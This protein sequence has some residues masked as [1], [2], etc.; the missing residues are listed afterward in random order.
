MQDYRRQFAAALTWHPGASPAELA[1]ALGVSAKTVQRYTRRG[2]AEGW[3]AG[4]TKRL[5]LTPAAESVERRAAIETSTPKPVQRPHSPRSRSRPRT[6]ERSTPPPKRAPTR[7][8][9]LE[10]G[11]E[12]LS[13]RAAARPPETSPPSAAESLGFFGRL[14]ALATNAG[15][16]D[17]REA[18]NVSAVRRAPERR[19]PAAL[20]VVG[21]GLE[22]RL[23]RSP[24]PA[25]VPAEVS[26]STVYR[27]DAYGRPL[28]VRR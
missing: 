3:L 18:I 13:A 23:E 20:P 2:R 12:A 21:P 27:V 7:T 25:P 6:T 16:L 24:R 11:T 10:V 28:V 19:E 9:L 17:A 22:I 14:V 8:G 15:E 4:T 5:Y 26:Q 1:G